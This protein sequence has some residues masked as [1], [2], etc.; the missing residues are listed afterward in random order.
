[1]TIR[2][3][4]KVLWLRCKGTP[5]YAFPRKS[6]AYDISGSMVSPEVEDFVAPQVG[7]E[8]VSDMGV[9]TSSGLETTH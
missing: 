4:L 5:G 9:R 6:E 8:A 3:L 1:M 2:C 7:E